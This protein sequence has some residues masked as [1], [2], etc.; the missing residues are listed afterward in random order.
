MEKDG[1]R[2]A[3]RQGGEQGENEGEIDGSER[4]GHWG[5][6]VRMQH[7]AP[8]LQSLK[9]EEQDDQRSPREARHGKGREGKHNLSALVNI[10]AVEDINES[11]E[12]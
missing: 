2:L 4:E 11:A 12:N 8:S 9:A 10:Q 5:G 6:A 3:S 1:T 7:E